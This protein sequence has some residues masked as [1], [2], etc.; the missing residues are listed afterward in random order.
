MAF[1]L[2]LPS[3]NHNVLIFLIYSSFTL[4]LHLPSAEQLPLLNA[5]L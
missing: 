3:P 1:Y 2:S 5:F 4:Q